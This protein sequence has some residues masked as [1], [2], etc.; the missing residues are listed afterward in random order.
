MKIINILFLLTILACGNLFAN[1]ASITALKGDAII[2]RG[3]Q[4]LE[5]KL[6][7]RLKAKDTIIT[8][9][10]KMQIIFKDDTIIS[11]GKNSK[12]I[13]NNYLYQNNQKSIAKFSILKGAMRTIT[14]QIAKIAPSKFMVNTTNATIG[15]RGTNFSVFIGKDDSFETFCTFG[16]IS[17]TINN[18]EHSVPQNYSLTLS[19]TGAINIQE[20]NIE[21]LQKMKRKS[22][23]ITSKKKSKRKNYSKSRNKNKNNILSST[24]NNEQIDTTTSQNNIIAVLDKVENALATA[25]AAAAEAAAEEIINPTETTDPDTIETVSSIVADYAMSDASYTGTYTTTTNT[26]TNFSDSGISQLDID[27]S[28]DSAT[29]TLG[30]PTLEL[31]HK[32]TDVKTDFSFQHYGSVNDTSA[33]GNGTATGKFYGTTGNIVKGDFNYDDGTYQS[34]GTYDATSSQTLN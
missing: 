5:A 26:N 1:V 32:S 6:G 20:F 33:S 19:S 27:F 11:I 29:L 31:I 21:D 12:F 24:E 14:G 2:K 13:I 15:I 9:N 3:M 16:E 28:A 10:A 22:F 17:V 8:K 18:K 7:A 4:N 34:V 30:A 23:T 25:E